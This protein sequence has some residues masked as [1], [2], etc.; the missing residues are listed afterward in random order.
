[1]LMF[2]PRWNSSDTNVYY[3][4]LVILT[5]LIQYSES[6]FTLSIRLVY[7]KIEVKETFN[8]KAS[9]SLNRLFILYICRSLI[10]RKWKTCFKFWWNNVFKSVI[11]IIDKHWINCWH[12][13]CQRGS[14]KSLFAHWINI[15][16]FT[17]LYNFNIFEDLYSPMKLGSRNSIRYCLLYT[18]FFTE[19]YTFG[20]IQCSY[21]K[22]CRR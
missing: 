11:F 19:L 9:T 22:H 5:L 7:Y 4:L 14:R 1:M 21:K 6:M 13:C 18:V 16:Y 8:A 10:G 12:S 15:A 17:Y 20:H 2:Y 3:D